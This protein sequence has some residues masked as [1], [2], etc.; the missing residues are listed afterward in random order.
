MFPLCMLDFNYLSICGGSGDGGGDLEQVCTEVYQQACNVTHAPSR[1]CVYQ[2]SGTSLIWTSEKVSGFQGFI[3]H[4]NMAAN[5][6]C[7]LR[8]PAYR[9]TDTR[10]VPL[11]NGQTITVTTCTLPDN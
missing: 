4:K 7:S 8:C 6:S 1:P 10:E 5:V 3:K 2:Y 11:F 9:C